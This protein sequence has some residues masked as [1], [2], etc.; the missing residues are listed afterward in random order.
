[1]W[2]KSTGVMSCGLQRRPTLSSNKALLRKTVPSPG[3]VSIV[4]IEPFPRSTETRFAVDV[5][6]P[7]MRTEVFD[8]ATVDQ[9]TIGK[10]DQ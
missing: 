4:C 8:L 5:A 9:Y 6:S 10:Q 1:M 7:A 2:R 3:P